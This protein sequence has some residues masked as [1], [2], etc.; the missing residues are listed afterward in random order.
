MARAPQLASTQE[1]ADVR[2]AL[3]LALVPVIVLGFARFAYGSVLPAMR[4]ELTWDYRDAAWPAITNGVGYLIGA[5]TGGRVAA[6]L[7]PARATIASLLATCTAILVTGLVTHREIISL[8]RFITGCT[9]AWA[10]VGGA[11]L[12]TALRERGVRM[13]M[14]WYPAGTGIGIAMSAII[15]IWVADRTRYWDETWLALGVLGFVSAV[16]I[17]RA[18]TQLEG[19]APNRA[20]S[21][22]GG[23]ALVGWRI[24]VAYGLF[25]AGYI[26]VATFGTSHLVDE[27]LTATAVQLFWVIAGIV[28][29]GSG[30]LWASYFDRAPGG[31][32]LGAPIACCAIAAAFFLAPASILTTCIAGLF[33]GAGL[34]NTTAGIST[35]IHRDLQPADWGRAFAAITAAFAVGQMIG[36]VS[37]L[38]TPDRAASAYPVLIASTI[39]LSLGA[40]VALLPNRARSL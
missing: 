6:R 5:L 10:Y 22:L 36:P 14:I 33:L 4:A 30:P 38:A 27:G 20:S 18:A 28:I 2:A 15:G 39:L 8:L 37:A 32:P 1:P 3:V 17:I 21:A 23:F 9:G 35:I 19:L 24:P 31:R 25:G 16:L 34:L 11:V 13:A 40:V 29:A 7:G 26:C 12:S